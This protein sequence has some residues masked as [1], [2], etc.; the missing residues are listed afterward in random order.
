MRFLGVPHIQ[1]TSPPAWEF[2]NINDKQIGR[3]IRKMKPYKATMTGTIPNSVFI[4]AKDM[5]IPYLGPLF[6]ATHN[7]PYYLDIWALTE[8]LV[9]KKPG[10]PDYCAPGAW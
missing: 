5:L 8:T 7:L 9:L 1:G 2:S 3:A 10:K 6:R 4:N